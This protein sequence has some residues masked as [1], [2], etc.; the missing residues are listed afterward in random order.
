MEFYSPAP[1]NGVT[2]VRW[3]YFNLALNIQQ[4][5][6]VVSWALRAENHP[7]D[8]VSASSLISGLTLLLNICILQEEE[9]GFHFFKRKNKKEVGM[10]CWKWSP[11]FCLHSAS[12]LPLR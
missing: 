8:W 3:G 6:N 2:D 10:L 4:E 9:G 11:G 7:G 12:I 5:R 1:G